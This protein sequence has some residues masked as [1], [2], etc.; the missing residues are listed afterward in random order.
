MLAF[1]AP[2]APNRGYGKSP[3]VVIGPHIYKSGVTPNIVN[4]IG[5]SSNWRGEPLREYETIVNL[6]AETTTAKG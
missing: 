6:I 2:P 4:A 5:I 1:V 3:G